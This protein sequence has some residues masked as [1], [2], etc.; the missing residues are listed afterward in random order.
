MTVTIVWEIQTPQFRAEMRLGKRLNRLKEAVNRTMNSYKKW[1]VNTI[2]QKEINEIEISTNSRLRWIVT[3]TQEITVKNAGSK[4]RQ[5]RK[6]LADL[7]DSD[8]PCADIASA[9]LKIAE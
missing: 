7:A 9:L 3:M 8:L 6:D 5:H 4:I 2:Q 1:S